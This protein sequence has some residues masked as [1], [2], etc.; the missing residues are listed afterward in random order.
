MLY[1]LKIIINLI[2]VASLNEKRIKT[3]FSFNQSAYLNYFDQ[4]V[5]FANNVHKQYLLKIDNNMII[6]LR[7]RQSKQQK[8][9]KKSSFYYFVVFKKIINFET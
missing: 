6:N 5:I 1:V 2:N 4:H 3:Y 9:Q 7:E 8:L